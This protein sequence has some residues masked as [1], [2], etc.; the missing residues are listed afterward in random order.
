MT[1]QSL[2][3]AALK[4]DHPVIGSDILA[5]GEEQVAVSMDAIEHVGDHL[6]VGEGVLPLVLRH[7]C[8]QRDRPFLDVDPAP[9]ERPDFAAALAGQDQ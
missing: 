4:F 6:A 8:R 1:L 5:A 9:F 3:N 7:R 2:S